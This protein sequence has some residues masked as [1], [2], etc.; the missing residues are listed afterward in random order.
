MIKLILLFY[1]L[2]TSSALILLKLGSSS[3]APMSFVDSKLTFN[4]NWV[5][6]LA[7]FLYVISF[8]CYTFLIAKLDLGFIIPLTTAFVYVTIFAASYLIFHEVFTI[9]KIAGIA[10]ILTGAILLTADKTSPL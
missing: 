1:V 2:T 8:L 5:I 3:G 10:L 6:L 4:L 9:M 7:G